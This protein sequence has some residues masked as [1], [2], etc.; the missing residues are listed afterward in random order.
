M[1]AT[2]GNPQASAAHVVEDQDEVLRFLAA[3]S[4]NAGTVT[5]IDTHGAVVFLA[6]EDAYKIK[7]AVKF[8]FM[9]FST[10]AKRREA[11]EAELRI[12]RPNA[13]DIYLDVLPVV[14]RDGA[15]CLGGPGDEVEWV[16]HMR[17][18]DERRTLDRIAEQD[19]LTPVLTERAAAAI[20][21]AQKH[22]A[23]RA[24]I[25]VVADLHGIIEGNRSSLDEMPDLFDP[26]RVAALT[27]RS[28]A[29][30]ERIAP[31][32]AARS[33][34]GF[35]RRCHGDLH[36]RNIVLLD[37][38]P[39][40]FDAL[41]FDEAL[42][43]IDVLYDFAFLLMDVIERGFAFEANHLLNRY[44]LEWRDERQ[45]AGL[46]A[47][48]LFISV[49]AAIRAKVV[50]AG[51]V[52]M[53]G[54]ER[55]AS[56]STAE[57]YFAVAEQALAP[58]APR[59]VAIGGLSGTGK[60]T[61]AARLAPGIGCMPGAVHLR[62]DV[63]RKQLF[64]VG[65]YDRLPESAY[66]RHSS[67]AVYRILRHKAELTLRSGYSAIV[68][69]VHLRGDERDALCDLASRLGVGFAGLWLAAP[70]SDLVSRVGQ[71][72]RDASDAR[73]DTVALQAG[74]D[75]GPIDWPVIDAGD[76]PAA[77]RERARGVLGQN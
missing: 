4:T 25:D 70:M 34:A 43:T 29:A 33:T 12:N 9:D 1:L 32:L 41:E 58:V 68:D 49:R 39:V 18:F 21:Q 2:S 24:G 50:A 45:L 13:P 28:N 72:M 3:L 77:V 53:S 42:A 51:L 61:L 44:L 67:D 6:G 5:R 59:L 40:L 62:S 7:R 26:A 20:V 76:D 64:G 27:D 74:R 55:Q 38:T 14:R 16:V 30:V 48:P 8:P 46:A 65:E 23:V 36:L 75:T 60:S 35:V 10:L 57:R 19:G 47:L 17:R 73:A 66:D 37:E 11:C 56:V 54:R 63:E 15:L 22:A 52:H 71:R 69:A 31:M